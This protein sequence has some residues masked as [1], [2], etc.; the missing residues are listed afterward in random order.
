MKLVKL[1]VNT[2]ARVGDFFGNR[3]NGEKYNGEGNSGD[4]GDLLGEQVYQRNTEKHEGN[5]AQSYGDFAP[6]N[7]QIQGDPVFAHARLFEPQH[8]NG[9]AFH[10]ETP[11][12]AEGISLAQEKNV[13]AAEENCQN[14]EANHHVD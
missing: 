11:N 13:A 1:L 9:K 7:V 10:D 12:H 14:L 8:Q 4:S 3:E 2:M 5:E 6:R